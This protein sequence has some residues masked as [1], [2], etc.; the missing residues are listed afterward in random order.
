E[1]Q[2]NI[3]AI[4]LI[5][6]VSDS[7]ILIETDEKQA[8]TLYGLH[9]KSSLQSFLIVLIRNLH[10]VFPHRLQA[11]V[12]I[13][14]ENEYDKLLRLSNEY[15]QDTNIM[16]SESRPCGGFSLRYECACFSSVS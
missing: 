1:S 16:S 7:H 5:E 3:L 6:R 9:D 11:I 12:E 13:R 15:Y 2:F 4:K 14:P 10:A 8:H